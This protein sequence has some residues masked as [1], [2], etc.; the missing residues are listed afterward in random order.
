MKMYD[1]LGFLNFLYLLQIQKLFFPHQL[2]YINNQSKFVIQK[3]FEKFVTI[4]LL[5]YNFYMLIKA[6]QRHFLLNLYLP[7]WWNKKIKL[8]GRRE[9]KMQEPDKSGSAFRAVAWCRWRPWMVTLNYK[10]CSS[11]TLSFL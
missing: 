5:K 10:K 2:F 3:L 1:I 8:M 7:V 9:P 6:Q 4:Y 11:I